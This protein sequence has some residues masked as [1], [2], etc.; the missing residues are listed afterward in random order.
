LVTRAASAI[1]SIDVCAYGAEFDIDAEGT[2]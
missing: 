2:A 1:S